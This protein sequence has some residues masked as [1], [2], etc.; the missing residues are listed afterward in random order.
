MGLELWE[1]AS[2]LQLHVAIVAGGGLPSGWRWG[3][4]PCAPTLLSLPAAGP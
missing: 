2:R 3:A 4:N 1:G